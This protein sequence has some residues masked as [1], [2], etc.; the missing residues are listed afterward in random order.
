MTCAGDLDE[1]IT[2]RPP[3]DDGN[4]LGGF[5]DSGAAGSPIWASF[6]LLT[7]SSARGLGV[8]TLDWEKFSER[9]LWRVTVRHRTVVTGSVVIDSSNVEYVV[10]A[11]VDE[12]RRGEFMTLIVQEEVPTGV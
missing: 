10:R 4:D 3:T 2:I 1:Q 8:D 12:T 11:A 7:Q 6:E 9:R 5:T